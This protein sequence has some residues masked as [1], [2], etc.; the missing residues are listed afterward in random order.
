[1][2]PNIPKKRAMCVAGGRYHYVLFASLLISK[3]NV[4]PKRTGKKHV[5]FD[6]VKITTAQRHVLSA[7]LP[8]SKWNA[9]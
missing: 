2:R 1:M 8:L 4:S 9:S 3:L 5:C 6:H 7:F